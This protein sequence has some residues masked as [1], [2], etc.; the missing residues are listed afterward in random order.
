MCAAVDGVFEY[1]INNHPSLEQYSQ[2][3]LIPDLQQS[4]VSTEFSTEFPVS[5]AAASFD[6]F[7]LNSVGI[8]SQT[9][10]SYTRLVGDQSETKRPARPARW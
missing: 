4:A 1:S 6:S 9:A 10:A 8:C 5:T 7:L 3:S 2:S